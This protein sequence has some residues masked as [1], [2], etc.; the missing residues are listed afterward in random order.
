MAL[1]TLSARNRD[2]AD[3]VKRRWRRSK[4]DYARTIVFSEFVGED[5]TD[6]DLLATAIKDPAAMLAAL[7]FVSNRT[8]VKRHRFV[9]GLRK[10]CWH[11]NRENRA[12]LIEA[13]AQGSESNVQLADLAIAGQL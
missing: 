10:L 1:A 7:E 4:Q 13:F 3:Q 12:R 11:R 9:A 2:V 5:V 6:D 8:R